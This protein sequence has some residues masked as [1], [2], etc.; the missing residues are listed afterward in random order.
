MKPNRILVT[1]MIAL[2]GALAP[3]LEAQAGPSKA[4]VQVPDAVLESNVKAALA[5]TLGRR[6]EEMAVLVH[7]G[8]VSLYGAVYSPAARRSAERSVAQVPGV[9]AVDNRLQVVRG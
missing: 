3:G 4:A 2:A 8:Y 6:S 5:A 7:D 9:K 1:M